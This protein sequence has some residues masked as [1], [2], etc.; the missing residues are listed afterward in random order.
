M[1]RRVYV[2]YY[3]SIIGLSVCLSCTVTEIFS[4]EYWR[5]LEMWVRGRSVVTADFRLV[6]HCK[7]SSM[8]YHS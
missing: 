8:L 5:D 7:Y 2:F 1:S 3:L 6:Y 4:A